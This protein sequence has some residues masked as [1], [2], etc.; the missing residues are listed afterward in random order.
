MKQKKSNVTW[1]NGEV[2]YIVFL[3]MLL[4][5]LLTILVQSFYDDHLKSIQNRNVKIGDE[6]QSFRH[7]VFLCSRNYLQE[8][9][10]QIVYQNCVT[11]ARIETQKNIINVMEND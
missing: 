3:A 4:T 6:L 7:Q 1:T 10:E 8:N 5:F 9:G 11:D 2:F